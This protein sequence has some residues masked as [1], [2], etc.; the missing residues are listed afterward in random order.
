MKHAAWKVVTGYLLLVVC[1]AY[2]RT[3]SLRA[4][5]CDQMAAILEE[6]PRHSWASC[7]WG[8]PIYTTNPLNPS[9]THSFL[10]RYSLDKIPKGQ[11]I[12][13]AEWNFS[14]HVAARNTRLFIWRILVDW[15]VGVNYNYRMLRPHP[16]AWTVPGARGNSSD[17]ATKPSIIL[18]INARGEQAVNVTEDVELWYT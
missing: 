8:M 18:N 2:G 1:S 14:P 3:V 9:A 10:I 16:L 4:E 15:G 7:S 17:R 6:G 13:Y 5:D 12:T 11:R